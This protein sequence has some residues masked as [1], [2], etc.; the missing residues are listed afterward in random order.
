M[1]L[2][3]HIIES[4]GMN[5]LPP[6]EVNAKLKEISNKPT[7]EYASDVRGAVDQLKQWIAEHEKSTHKNPINQESLLFRKCIALEMMNILAEISAAIPADSNKEGIADAKRAALQKRIEQLWLSYGLSYSHEAEVHIYQTRLANY[8]GVF[9]QLY[10]LVGLDGTPLHANP[11]YDDWKLQT[12]YG[13][14]VDKMVQQKSA[15]DFKYADHFLSLASVTTEENLTAW[16]KSAPSS[17]LDRFK[18]NA[19][20]DK[21]KTITLAYIKNPDK[22]EMYMEMSKIANGLKREHRLNSSETNHLS[23]N[24]MK[25]ANGN[26]STHRDDHNQH[27]NNNNQKHNGYKRLSIGSDN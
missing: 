3:Q 18:E 21:A 6:A 2:H 25:P 26:T 24:A 5:Y 9:P 4:R 1:P 27:N 17:A 14:V 15:E 19:Y 20:A 22:Q 13:C 23:L 8:L 10:R 12:L 7:N 11:K 16:K